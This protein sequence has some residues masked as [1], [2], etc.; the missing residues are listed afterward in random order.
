MR[1]TEI[2]IDHFGVLHDLT[3]PIPLD[4]PFVLLGNNE[5]GKSTLLAFLR[6]MLFGIPR[7]RSKDERSY[8]MAEHRIGAL[9]LLTQSYGELRLER[10]R[11]P[12]GGQVT[13]TDADGVERP[14]E[15]LHQLVGGVDRDVY[16]TIYGFSLDELQNIH[17]VT[18]DS[19]ANAFHAASLGTDR[20]A[21]QSA[22]DTLEKQLAQLFKPSGRTQEAALALGELDTV[23]KQLREHEGE[24][25][26]FNRMQREKAEQTEQRQ[27]LHQKAE[28]L[29][30]NLAELKKAASAWDD[31]VDL[32]QAETQLA[33]LP[34]V[35]DEFPE[36]GAARIQSL[37]DTLESLESEKRTTETERAQ[38]ETEWRQLNTEKRFEP[39]AP[40]IRSL[41]RRIP[42]IQAAREEIPALE[43]TIQRDEHRLSELLPNLGPNCTLDELDRV[44]RSLDA[45]H[46]LRSFREQCNAARQTVSDARQQLDTL[47]A[48]QEDLQRRIRNSETE[49]QEQLAEIMPRE[50]L[51]EAPDSETVLTALTRIPGTLRQ[52]EAVRNSAPIK[53]PFAL[54]DVMTARQTERV[55]G[56]LAA[57][58]VLGSA[59]LALGQATAWSASLFACGVL[60]ACAVAI[61]RVIRRGHASARQAESEAT[62]ELVNTTE[63]LL[64]SG[65]TDRWTALDLEPRVRRIETL[66]D[67]LHTLRRES[68]PLQQRCDQ[69]K[70]ALEAA[71]KDLEDKQRQWR[72]WRAQHGLPENAT[73]EMASDILHAVEQA[74]QVRDHLAET[75]TQRAKRQDVLDQCRTELSELQHLIPE[76]KREQTAETQIQTLADNLE[77]ESEKQRRAAEIQRQMRCLENRVQEIQHQINDAKS[78]RNQL[79]KTARVNS[80]DE[81]LQLDKTRRERERLNQ[82]ILSHER[83]LRAIYGPE[84]LEAAR[85]TLA[86]TNPVLL[87]AR[88]D[89]TDNALTDA[90]NQLRDLDQAIGELNKEIQLLSTDTQVSRLKSERATLRARLQEIS[91]QWLVQRSAEHLIAEAR[92]RFEEE[93]QPEVIRA[94]SEFLQTFT[95]GRYTRIIAELEDAGALA[96]LH[97]NGE[98]VPTQALSRG[99]AEQLYLALRLGYIAATRA[100]AEALPVI[101]DD[102]LVNFDSSRRAAAANAIA[103]FAV[104]TQVLYFTCHYETTRPFQA[105]TKTKANICELRNGTIQHL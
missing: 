79:L 68:A 63:E 95:H 93:R 24:L 51:A 28:S 87:N 64:G 92:R 100:G 72:Q 11:G 88:L 82:Q 6:A 32:R 8:P 17:T 78:E 84:N 23:E 36:N 85:Q 21:L 73:P 105:A 52:L 70:S 1:I 62:A 97:Q 91:R 102:I 57:A 59:L 75:N 42:A 90:N 74:V 35:P 43:E 20:V 65:A 30:L 98:R 67:R 81:F 19:V 99:T 94:A 13:I 89:K 83:A 69:A 46:K 2:H 7:S 12:H 80:D 103:T 14:A 9:K 86:D 31:W 48:Q 96:I 37:R 45:Q 56:A 34:A 26:K 76:N 15:L 47:Q 71:E 10:R 61:L 44:D 38:L 50:R 54:V 5:A 77:A 39:N 53:S 66:R 22:R 58:C 49:I 27:S 40:R 29:R 18:G 3:V 41:V 16:R 4:G 25:E 33:E 104:H 60:C 55:G 101:M